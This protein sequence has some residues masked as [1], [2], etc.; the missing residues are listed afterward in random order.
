MPLL[1]TQQPAFA[2]DQAVQ[3]LGAT[4]QLLEIAPLEHLGERV[5]ERPGGAA[6]GEELAVVGLPPLLDHLRYPGNRD[7]VGTGHRRAALNDSSPVSGGSPFKLGLRVALKQTP[8]VVQ[9]AAHL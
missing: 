4:G 6:I 8:R 5:E 9:F 3:G 2:V 1:P 7:D